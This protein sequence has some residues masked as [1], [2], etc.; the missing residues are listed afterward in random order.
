MLGYPELFYTKLHPGVDLIL[1]KQVNKKIK[2][3]FWAEANLGGF[4]HRFFQTAAK[5]N[6]N[7][8]YR[9]FF[10]TRIYSDIGIG[11]GYLHSFYHYQVFKLNSD[12]DYVKE[13][14][15]KG[16]PQFLM[17]ICLGA[18]FGVKKS[19]PDLLRILIQF[20]SNAQGIFSGSFVPV[21][22]YNTFLIGL[23]HRVNLCKKKNEANK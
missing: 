18:G 9:Y 8:H 5:L 22:P 3:Q 12:G 4:Y 2:N 19:D 16:R 6:V 7:L 14:G 20:R 11:G 10:N 1:E 13:S 23:S 21:V 15:I 17:G